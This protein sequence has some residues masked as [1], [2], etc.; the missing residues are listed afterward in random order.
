MRRV[1]RTSTRQASRTRRLT[2]RWLAAALI[3]GAVALLAPGVSYATAGQAS[4]VTAGQ[5]SPVP[6]VHGQHRGDR[7][8]CL[9]QIPHQVGLG[10][11]GVRGPVPAEHA[12]GV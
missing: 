1:P 6:A 10:G 9:P 2:G 5:A 12:V 3:V 11:A 8:A 7:V 4:P